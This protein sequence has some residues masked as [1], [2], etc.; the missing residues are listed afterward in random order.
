MSSLIFQLKILRTRYPRNIA[1]VQN[2]GE[3]RLCHNHS[4]PLINPLEYNPGL[5]R[6]MGIYTMTLQRTQITF[7]AMYIIIPC[8]G[9]SVA[10]LLTCFVPVRKNT[11]ISFAAT[12]SLSSVVFLHDVQT[13]LPPSG[14]AQSLLGMLCFISFWPIQFIF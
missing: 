12:M 2:N 11:Q 1:T 5:N 10:N 8:S 6:S 13:I 7:Y 4:T 14:D 3:W 9:L